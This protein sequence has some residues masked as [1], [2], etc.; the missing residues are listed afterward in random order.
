MLTVPL[1]FPLDYLYP[2]ETS[3]TSTSVTKLMH[4][5]MQ[6]AD[7][8]LAEENKAFLLDCAR[9]IQKNSVAYRISPHIEYLSFLTRHIPKTPEQKELLEIF[10]TLYLAQRRIGDHITVSQH[11]AREDPELP[12]ATKEIMDNLCKTADGLSIML[13]KIPEMQQR[14]AEL[15][16]VG[17]SN[18]RDSILAEIEY[19]KGVLESIVQA[20]AALNEAFENLRA[21][22]KL[23]K[24]E[25]MDSYKAK[26]KDAVN[27]QRATFTDAQDVQD[28]QD[29]T[30]AAEA[31]AESENNEADE[32]AIED[33]SAD[34]QV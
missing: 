5:L 6:L 30:E 15:E 32:C 8:P 18:S 20:K 7:S 12:Q 17:S 27:E 31:E 3:H 33:P 22:Y 26:L 23:K 1:T 21:D 4:R 16:E 19:Q 13:A 2:G 9:D 10:S 11:A 25:L 28:I 29:D 34:A 24:N 14:I